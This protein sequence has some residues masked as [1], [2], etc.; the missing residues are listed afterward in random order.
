VLTQIF[1]TVLDYHVTFTDIQEP[2]RVN[3]AGPDNGSL[4]IWIRQGDFVS[5]T[6]EGQL[7]STTEGLVWVAL[8]HRYDTAG[9]HVVKLTVSGQLTLRGPV[10]RTE[11]AVN[12]VVRARPSLDDVMGHVTLASQSQPAYVDD[13]VAFVYAVERTVQNVSYRVDFGTG[14]ETEV[15]VTHLC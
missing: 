3:P 1:W 4:P 15:R 7:A 13:L 6:G 9:N 12:V 5:T 8:T 14:G 10:Q 11:A 2:R